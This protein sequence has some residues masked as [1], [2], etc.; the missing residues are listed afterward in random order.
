[1]DDLKSSYDVVIIGGAVVGS[2]VAYW[3]SSNPDFDGSTLVIERDP[4]Y[5]YA[6]TALSGSAIRQQFSEPTNIKMC[7][8]GMHFIKNVA[9][10]LTVENEQPDLGLQEHGYLVSA[11]KYPKAVKSL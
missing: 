10:Y 2:S 7:L 8:F 3:L 9:D 4:T 5:R 11:R 1:M 6:S